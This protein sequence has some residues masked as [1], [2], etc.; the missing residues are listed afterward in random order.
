V[1]GWQVTQSPFQR[2][3]GLASVTACVGAGR[4]GYVAVDMDAAEVASFT[5]AASDTWAGELAPR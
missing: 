2:R 3:A 5:A 4:G 1:V